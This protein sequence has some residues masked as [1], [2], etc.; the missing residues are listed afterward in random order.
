MK[1]RDCNV[2]FSDGRTLAPGEY[3]LVVRKEEES[4]VM[5]PEE[6]LALKQALEEQARGETISHEDL[7]K[8]LGL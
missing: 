3:T 8:E 7:M 5:T 2:T 1:V 6:E 4:D